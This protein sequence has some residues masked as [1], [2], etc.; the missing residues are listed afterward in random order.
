M[1]ADAHELAARMLFEAGALDEAARQMENALHQEPRL[2]GLDY[3]ALRSRALAG[4]WED[5]ERVLLGPVDR[6]SAFNYWASRLRLGFW[7]G[8]PSWIEGIDLA[9]AEGLGEPE[10]LLAARSA[11]MLR[12]KRSVPEVA[13]QL[14]RACVSKKLTPRVHAFYRQ[15]R[16]EVCAYLGDD[17][18]A[19]AA[20]RASV[21]AGLF[22]T[23]WLEGCPILARVRDRADVADAAATVALR[24]HQVR[25]ALGA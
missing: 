3:V 6:R 22:D 5:A 1:S 9:H 21:E 19:A 14:E 12:E 4:D 25:E 17:D 20:I 16:A 10:R 18:G 2:E 7:R 11:L 8:D 24:A 23:L 13:Q 15:L